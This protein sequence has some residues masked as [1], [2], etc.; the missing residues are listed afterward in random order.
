MNTLQKLLS[1]KL[2]QERAKIKEYRKEMRIDVERRLYDLD[3]WNLEIDWFI[4][5]RKHSP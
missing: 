3:Q 1:D 5:L 2:V 4:K